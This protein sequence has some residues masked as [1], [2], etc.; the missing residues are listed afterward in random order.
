MKSAQRS[1]WRRPSRV[2]PIAFVS[3]MVLGLAGFKMASGLG[4]NRELEEIRAK[5]LPANPKELDA[6][7]KPVPESEN[8][9]AEVLKASA[10][11]VLP[12]EDRNPDMLYSWRDVRKGERLPALLAAAASEYVGKNKETLEL[13]QAVS[14]H[15]RSRYPVDVSGNDVNPNLRSIRSMTQLL[16]WDA[17]LKAENGDAAGAGRT[18]KAGFALADSL[19]DEPVLISTLFR[20]TCATVQVEAVAQAVNRVQCDDGALAE[21]A[22]LA[23]ETEKAGKESFYRAMV[24]E[25]VLGISNFREVTF[26]QYEQIIRM[27]FGPAW[28]A[29]VP[30]PG[31]MVLFRFRKASGMQNSDFSFFVEQMSR[32]VRAAEL[33]HTEMLRDTVAAFKEM[34]GEFD[35]HPIRLMN[36]SLRLFSLERSAQKE[37]MLAARLRCL[38]GALA[39]ERFRMGHEG[40]MP[41]VEELVPNYL[42]AWLRDPVNNEPLALEEQ[43]TGGF[44]VIAKGAS[45]L[46]NAGRATTSTNWQDVAFVFEK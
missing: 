32:L 19:K 43:S 40:R 15:G 12:A 22:A 27:G 11:L 44:R 30:Y 39:V 24:G 6:W 46:Q 4:L 2:I 8:I 38:R 23:L 17:I 20:I 28:Y 16:R 1:W 7:Y 31:R 13:L 33:D 25:L 34:N 41:S 37:V 9:A 36:S 35:A 21:I 29:D 3:L 14:A 42:D 45:A 26:E 10:V 18:L 5:G